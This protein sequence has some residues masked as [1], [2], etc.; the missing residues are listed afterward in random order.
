M[1][2]KNGVPSSPSLKGN[3]SF[4]KIQVNDIFRK[5]YKEYCKKYKGHI[6]PQQYRV[7]NSLIA[8]RTINLGGHLYKCDSCEK[9]HTVYNS[10]KNRHCPTCQSLKAAEWLL[11]R[12]SELLPVQ[13]F[14]VVFTV[15]DY[16]NPLFLQNK[17][18]MYTLLFN[19]VSKTLT[20]LSAEQ[21]YLGVGQIG[22][23]SVLHT[24]SQ[25]LLDH[26]HI[27][28]IVTG[29]GLSKDKKR[30]IS[31]KKDYLIN[32]KVM[33][34]RFR[35]IFL[36]GLKELY[37]NKEL[38]FHGKIKEFKWKNVFQKLIDKLFTKSWV[39]H[40]EANYSDAEN[41]FDYLGRYVQKV[42][43]S[44][45]RII[46][47]EDNKVHF[48]YKDYADN[49]K[50]KIMVLHAVEFIRR[51]LLH[52]LPKRFV[53]IRYYGL[54]GFKNRTEKIT[55]CRTLLGVTEDVCHEKKVPECWKELYEFVM[56]HGVDRCPYCKK[57]HLIFVRD[58]MPQVM[59]RGP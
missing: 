57:G 18:I 41:I 37:K 23:I 27:H 53:K 2:E 30:W 25:T 43:I 55:L 49:G 26:P 47:I 15:P 28:T 9:F 35:S 36:L 4:K 16:L 1:A 54:L 42:A 52:V 33:S 51:F 17:K 45:N 38:H 12:R 14:H 7:I 29:G 19:S 13:Y 3:C 59:S 48:S 31:S 24:W 34:Q 5:Y 44:N 40:S 22:Y 8:C 32:V 50:T 39:V 10:C 20:Q 58:I 11:K 21:K 6:S 46:K 56:G